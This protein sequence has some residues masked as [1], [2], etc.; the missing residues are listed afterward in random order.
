MLTFEELREDGKRLKPEGW[1]PPDIRAKLL[2]QGW[3]GV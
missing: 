1:L 2:E 3:E